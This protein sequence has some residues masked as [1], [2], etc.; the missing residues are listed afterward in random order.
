[1]LKGIATNKA[2]SS[3][4]AGPALNGRIEALK[5]LASALAH[6]VEVLSRMPTS[7]GPAG[8]NLSEEVRR[9]EAEMIRLALVQTG[10]CQRRA[11]RLL[12]M[13]LTTLHRKIRHYGID[14]NEIKRQA[15][16][17]RADLR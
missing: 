4:E 1:M 11:V 9:F 10:G 15:S 7:G 16:A 14:V 8:I 12:G 6:E 3:G 17:A 5:V 2:P 13:K